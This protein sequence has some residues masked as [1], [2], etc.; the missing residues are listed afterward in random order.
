[1]QSRW[2]MQVVVA[3]LLIVSSSGAQ[4][5]PTA[6]S[7]Q[8]QSMQ[9]AWWTGPLLANSANT[10]PRGHFLAEPYLYDVISSHSHSF[11]SRTYLEYGVA[12]K[13]TV[14]AIPVFGYNKPDRGPSS[15]GLQ[16]GDIT[17]LAQYRLTKFREGSRVPTTAVQI[18]QTFPNGKYDRLG[19]RPSDGLGAGAYTTMAALN[20]QTYFWVPN[21]RILRMRFNVSESFSSNVDI[22]DVSVYGTKEGFRGHAEPGRSLFVD[23]AW[24]YSATRNWVLALDAIFQHNMNTWISGVQDGKALRVDTGTSWAFGFAPGVEYNL[25]PTLGVIFGARFIAPGHN[26]SGSVA[27]VIA[28]N[29]V[30]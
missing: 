13:L 30:H 7:A 5:Q 1:M 3:V 18:Q 14:G 10:L 16:V 25:S 21:G 2:V 29:F 12:D 20:T 28:I 4:E 26:S 27:P 11:G 23:A 17:L 8:R 22:R 6:P 9:D 24:E 19:S 15:S